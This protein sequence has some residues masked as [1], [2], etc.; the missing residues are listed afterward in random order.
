MSG[1][2]LFIFSPH[3]LTHHQY[4]VTNTLNKLFPC[5]SRNFR[6]LANIFYHYSKEPHAPFTMLEVYCFPFAILDECEFRDA[7]KLPQREKPIT[8]EDGA[9]ISSF[10]SPT[11]QLSLSASSFTLRFFPNI[12]QIRTVPSWANLCIRDS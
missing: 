4:I 5:I 7:M 10:L 6:Y 3:P 9:P 8:W 12:S 1:F 11:S 2:P